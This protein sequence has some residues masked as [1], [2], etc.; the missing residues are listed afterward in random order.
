MS[1]ETSTPPAEADAA[2]VQRMTA[3]LRDVTVT[4]VSDRPLPAEAQ[5]SSPP[6]ALAA[7]RRRAE[8]KQKC[9]AVL[10][11]LQEHNFAWIFNQPVDPVELGLNVRRESF[12][13]GQFSRRF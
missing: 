12:R 8:I 4:T 2:D 13:F 7:V 10:K 5:P 9:Q 11:K 1:H 6:A 3:D